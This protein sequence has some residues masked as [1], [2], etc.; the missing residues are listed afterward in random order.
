MLQ[1]GFQPI[2]TGTHTHPVTDVSYPPKSSGSKKIRLTGLPANCASGDLTVK[3]HVS[4][5]HVSRIVADLTGPADEWGGHQSVDTDA[6]AHARGS[7]LTAKVRTSRL[8]ANPLYPEYRFYTLDF[9]ATTKGHP[10][11]ELIRA[12]KF[13]VC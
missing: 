1:N 13:Q 2:D 6:I 5:A 11:H 3:A 10:S 12:V 7:S 8:K 9:T 4:G